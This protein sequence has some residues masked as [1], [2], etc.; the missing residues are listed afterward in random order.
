MEE[1]MISNLKFYKGYQIDENKIAIVKN[2]AMKR[3]D[4]LIYTTN[5]KC[6]ENIEMLSS[7]YGVNENDL[8]LILGSN[9]FLFFEESPVYVKFLEWVSQKDSEKQISQAVEIL[10]VFKDIL[11]NNRDKLFIA[12]MRHD[13]SYSFYESMIKRDYFSEVY[14]IINV[15]SCFGNTP[16]EIMK[17]NDE[18]FNMKEYLN[19]KISKEH[20]EFLKYIIHLLGF[21]VTDKF[22]KRQEKLKKKTNI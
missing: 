13:S 1:H 15:D 2:I 14:H 6:I 19:S 8:N 20:P 5:Y 18:Y 21:E 16:K 10:R 12:N 7:L 4:S 11:Y 9:W 17:L 3:Y 22:I